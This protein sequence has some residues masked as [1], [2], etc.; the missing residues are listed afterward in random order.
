MSSKVIPPDGSD[1]IDDN[2]HRMHLNDQ[3]SSEVHH[4]LG[5]DPSTGGN[6]P[7]SPGTPG[8]LAAIAL[9]G[10]MMAHAVDWIAV[11]NKLSEDYAMAGGIG[12]KRTPLQCLHMWRQVRR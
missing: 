2:Q 7:P 4:Q 10:G 9:A 5:N 6:V 12:A 11:S 8:P 1:L 3:Q